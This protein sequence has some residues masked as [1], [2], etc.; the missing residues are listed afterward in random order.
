M[1]PPPFLCHT[2]R[3]ELAWTDTTATA[4]KPGARAA[5][6]QGTAARQ[7]T[8]RLQWNGIRVQCATSLE[9]DP[10]SKLTVQQAIQVNITQNQG[11]CEGE[12]C[13]HGAGCPRG[14]LATRVAVPGYGAVG[15]R[16][17]I[18]NA[19]SI[20]TAPGKTPS[21][22]KSN[23]ITMPPQSWQHHNSTSHPYHRS[24]AH[25]SHAAFTPLFNTPQDTRMPKLG[26]GLPARCSYKT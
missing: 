19:V 20:D 3:E 5:G 21:T 14:R 17:H 7:S 23:R 13:R 9:L 11:R 4:T 12:S 16:H 10:S 26:E 8:N 1:V 2:I 22:H 24:Q 18:H 6:G 15:C 25:H